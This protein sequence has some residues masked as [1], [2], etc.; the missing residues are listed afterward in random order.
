[1]LTNQSVTAGEPQEK[2]QYITVKNNPVHVPDHVPITLLDQLV[3]SFTSFS[4]DCYNCMIIYRGVPVNWR[5]LNGLPHVLSYLI[6]T[7]LTIHTQLIQHILQLTSSIVQSAINSVSFSNYIYAPTDQLLAKHLS[8]RQLFMFP[9]ASLC[10]SVAL[11]C[12]PV[13]TPI[14][15]QWCTVDKTSHER[16]WKK[17]HVD[18]SLKHQ[19]L[20]E[21]WPNC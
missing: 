5:V 6:C 9:F 4:L 3:A 10:I 13:M 11:F 20:T 15:L 12:F 21:L 14:L 2:E 7:Y 18:R 16:A 1:M 19:H 17:R 8:V